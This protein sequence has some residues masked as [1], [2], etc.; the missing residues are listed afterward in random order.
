[1][2]S[3]SFD[4]LSRCDYLILYFVKISITKEIYELIEVSECGS[5]DIW[6]NS[7]ILL[8]YISQPECFRIIIQLVVN[9]V[10]VFDC[11]I[12]KGTL[13][14]AKKKEVQILIQRQSI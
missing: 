3:S 9:F 4:S 2:V 7:R 13:R 1:M 6:L 8:A 5:E 10:A 11:S 14:N 12:W